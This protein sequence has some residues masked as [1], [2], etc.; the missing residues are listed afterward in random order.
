MADIEQGGGKHKGGKQRSKKASTH[1]DMTAMVDLAF[2]LVTFFMLTTTFSKPQTMEINMP[3]KE[4]NLTEKPEVKAST[5]ITLLL[6]KDNKVVYYEGLPK[7]GAE[8]VTKISDFSKDG[9]RKILLQKRAQVDSQNGGTDK[10]KALAIIKPDDTSNYKNMVDILDEMSIT[11]IKR[12]AILD[13]SAVEKDM[14]KS[15]VVQ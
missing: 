15:A 11:K 8:T 3:D 10:D 7:E 4:D 12:Y 5:V 1:V 13:I 14:I 6:T 9:I 2:L